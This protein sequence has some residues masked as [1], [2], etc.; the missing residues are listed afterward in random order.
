MVAM[1]MK[2]G[3]KAGR[4]EGRKKEGKT[5]G[6]KEGFTNSIYQKDEERIFKRIPLKT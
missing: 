3:K 5:E 6:R 1:V 4:M 2:E